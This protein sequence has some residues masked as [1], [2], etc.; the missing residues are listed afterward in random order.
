VVK[1]LVNLQ[2]F[3]H[4]AAAAEALLIG[5]R[6]GI[7]LRALHASFAAGPARSSF[8][9]HEALEVLR[10]GEYG[11]RF[12]LGLVAKDLRLAAALARQTDVPAAVSDATLELYERARQ[13][14]GDGA[15]EMAV[16][17]FLEELTGT[18]LRFAPRD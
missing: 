13:R 18:A 9:V 15:G 11:E 1:L 2:W 3:V 8:I 16:L 4:A 12:P 17:A 14:L 5:A 6:A 7:D 10:D